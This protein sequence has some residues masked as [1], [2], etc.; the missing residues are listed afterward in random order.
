M[1]NLPH[2]H[3][4]NQEESP[5][6]DPKNDGLNHSGGRPFSSLLLFDYALISTLFL[7]L[8]PVFR[9]AHLPLRIDFAGMAGAYWGGT[10]AQTSFFAILLAIVGLPLEDTLL[11]FFHRCREQKVRIL[12]SVALAVLMMY[13]F[14]IWLGFVI[15]VDAMALTE[16][17]D[18][19]KLKFESCLLD[20]FIPALYLFCG[21]M[22]VFAF[23][24]AIAGIK[25]A[26]T[27][28]ESFKHLD[29]VLFRTSVSQ[30]SHWSFS[31][32]PL[33]FFRLLEFAYYSLYG[34][35]GAALVLSALLG[36]QKYAL[37]YVATL[38]IGY[39]IALVVFFAWP[40]IGPFSICAIHTSSYPRSLATYITQTTIL[41]K[42]RL[43]WAHTLTS[44]VSLV[45]VADYYI[46]FPC[47]HVALPSIAIWFLRP[48]KRMALCLLIFDVVLLVPSIIFLEW[49][50]LVDLIAGLFV[51]FL[52]IK[53]SQRISNPQP[54][55]A[56]KVEVVLQ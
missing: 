40:T 16:L 55:A 11:P 9:L 37:R 46:G 19:M 10:A 35:I 51:A 33:W 18:R 49:H 26:G 14:G 30:I 20:V 42:A 41:E 3:R 12:A 38:L 24:H 47:M 6:T 43:L 45:N 52:A 44:N 53:L 23:N 27:C 4:G 31:H 13:F 39:S 25:F 56:T 48:W 17:M 32:F 28:D 36:S 34:Q 29:L 2:S 54:L 1:R 22:L 5:I 21:V 50:Y 15:T 8:F 7:L